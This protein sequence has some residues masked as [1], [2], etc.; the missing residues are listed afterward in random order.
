MT[1]S[2]ETEE[3]TEKAK[4]N[5]LDAILYKPVRHNETL[6]VLCKV[7]PVFCKVMSVC[8]KVLSVLRVT[9]CC[10][11]GPLCLSCYKVS[12]STSAYLYSLF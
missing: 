7:L 3:L 6:S 12:P 5:G 8:R 2:T 10:S 4:M 1:A 9:C 11:L